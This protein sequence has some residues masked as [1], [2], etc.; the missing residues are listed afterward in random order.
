VVHV[1]YLLACLVRLS[2]DQDFQPGSSSRHDSQP[3]FQ[4]RASVTLRTTQRKRVNHWVMDFD[5][6][7]D[8]A[9]QEFVHRILSALANTEA[10]RGVCICKSCTPHV[11][12][13]V[14]KPRIEVRLCDYAIDSVAVQWMQSDSN[15]ECV[16]VL[17][18]GWQD[19]EPVCDG[20][21]GPDGEPVSDSFA[22]AYVLGLAV[23]EFSEALASL[24]DSAEMV[25]V[26]GHPLVQVYT[27]PET[28]QL[29]YVGRICNFRQK[30]SSFISSL[31]TFPH[32]MPFVTVRPR[33]LKNRRNSASPCSAFLSLKRFN[34][35]HHNIEWIDSAEKAWRE[36]D[37]QIGQSREGLRPR[38]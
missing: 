24:A 5:E 1:R 27:I 8:L 31:P 19:G 28:G 17:H 3:W 13:Y 38:T 15:V 9:A 30:V 4:P 37:V 21:P 16:C 14:L 25:L 32:D 10:G 6:G 26:L 12:E 7:Q 22:P 2:F 11:E 20:E 18:E 33:I 36:D 34:P 35:Y 23:R 29:A